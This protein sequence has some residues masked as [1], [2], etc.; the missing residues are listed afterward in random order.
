[1]SKNDMVAFPRELSD[2]LA[3]LIADRARV[4]G[5]GAFEIWEAIVEGFGTPYD[6]HKDIAIHALNGLI[7]SRQQISE[8][9]HADPVALPARIDPPK[10]GES[11]Q[12][13]P[14]YLAWNACLDEIAK[15]G[16]LYPKCTALK[17]CTVRYSNSTA[18]VEI[19][20]LTDDDIIE[21]MGEYLNVADG[22]YVIDTAPEYVVKAGRALLARAALER[23]P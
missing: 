13:L 3:E 14:R 12:L 8:Q 11:H 2:E 22:G 6:D 18:P 4:C 20:E 9:H 5:G 7:E 16:P 10:N 23:K 15:L 1:M 21:A 17:D 19:D